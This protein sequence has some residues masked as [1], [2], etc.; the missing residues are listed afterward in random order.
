[1]NRRIKRTPTRSDRPTDRPKARGAHA[2]GDRVKSDRPKSDR[3]QSDRPNGAG[4]K[5]DRPNSADDRA[6]RDRTTGSRPGAK[7]PRFVEQRAEK[8]AHVEALAH[9]P[10]PE[11]KP[12]PAQP[13]PTKVQTFVVTADENNMRIDRF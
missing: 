3:F 10:E 8:R 11:A 5:N 9:R 12:V 6:P 4:F 13:L 2:G 7:T 1:M